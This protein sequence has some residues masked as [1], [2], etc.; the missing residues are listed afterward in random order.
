M[1]ED[2]KRSNQKAQIEE[3]TIHSPR[4]KEQKDKQ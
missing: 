3:H 4:E 1:F 2:I